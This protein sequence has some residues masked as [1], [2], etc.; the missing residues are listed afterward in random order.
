MQPNDWQ[1]TY[2]VQR[3]NTANQNRTKSSIL[4]TL[5]KTRCCTITL[6]ETDIH[7]SCEDDSVTV[8]ESSLSVRNKEQFAL[9][10]VPILGMNT[11]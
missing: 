6:K 9:V 4:G 11:I 1:E 7:S 10:F 8:T 5:Q 3:S 2:G